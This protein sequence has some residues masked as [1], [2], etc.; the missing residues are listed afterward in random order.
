MRLRTLLLIPTL[1]LAGLLASPSPLAYAQARHAS[2]KATTSM[3][4]SDVIA[5]SSAGLGDDVVIAKIHAA[6]ST[7]FDTSVQGLSALKAAGVSSA[8]IR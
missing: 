5:L 7:N 1:S 2:T 4:N 8:V 3:S 6:A